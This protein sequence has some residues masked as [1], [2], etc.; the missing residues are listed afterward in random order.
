MNSSTPAPASFALHRDFPAVPPMYAA[1]LRQTLNQEQRD[2]HPDEDRADAVITRTVLEVL[3]VHDGQDTVEVIDRR[4]VHGGQDGLAIA[5]G[6]TVTEIR[7]HLL[8]EPGALRHTLYPVWCPVDKLLDQRLELRVPDEI[9]I[10]ATV[11]A[12]QMMT[13]IT[14]LIYLVLSLYHKDWKNLPTEPQIGGYLITKVVAQLGDAEQR[15]AH[16]EKLVVRAI[17]PHRTAINTLLGRSTCTIEL[18]PT[19]VAVLLPKAH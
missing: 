8:T 7:L 2:L 12:L 15:R 11:P 5:S 18:S 9:S 6:T 16:L 13:T 1:W 4:D 17:E 10:V 19:T 14:Q 3:T